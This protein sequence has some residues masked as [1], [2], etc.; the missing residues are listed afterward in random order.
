MKKPF[1]ILDLYIIKK[2]LGTY[3]F[4][5]LLI[6]AITVMFDINEK[7]DSFLKAPIHA[8]IFDYFLK[9]GRAHV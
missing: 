1:K 4:A 5:I 6:L 7:L 2:F 3:F 9:I 8:T